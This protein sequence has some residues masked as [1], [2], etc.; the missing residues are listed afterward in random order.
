M[1]NILRKQSLIFIFGLLCIGFFSR[2]HAGLYHPESDSI[3]SNPKKKAFRGVT[4]NAGPRVMVGANIFITANFIYWK[5]VQE[6]TVSA[7][8]GV[9]PGAVPNPPNILR[10][11]KKGTLRSVGR[12]W[13]AGFKGGFG[14]NLP[15]DGWDICASYT[16]LHPNNDSSVKR[17]F[18]PTTGEGVISLQSPNDGY[19]PYGSSNEGSYYRWDR[20]ASHWSLN[21]NM[22][23]LELG[24]NFYLSQFLTMR[25]FVG[26]KGT[27]QSQ[28]LN[29]H[30]FIANGVNLGVEEPLSGPYRI[31]YN[32]DVWGIGPRGGF[33]IDWYLTK[34]WSLYGNMACTSMWAT[35]TDLK[36]EDTVSNFDQVLG[37]KT[38]KMV[39]TD[40]DHY[41]SV[42]WIGEIGFGFRWEIWLYNHTYHFAIQSGWENQVWLNWTSFQS[43]I[44]PDH[45][46]NLSFG[47]LNLKL[48]ID[49]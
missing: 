18:N 17:E 1:Q 31:K 6:G 47:G 8:S 27:W 14:V 49:F 19:G 11:A 21:F 32:N 42:K 4:P 41:D 3:L 2:G 44:Q 16:Y 36:R 15:H 48:R 13:S 40:K 46:E 28:S 33:N 24:R 34:N 43:I 9:N 10:S 25:P 12:D 39:N 30:L 22:I 23:D 5:A 20:I 37:H 7:I 29:T 38:P 45:W 26:L 35:Y